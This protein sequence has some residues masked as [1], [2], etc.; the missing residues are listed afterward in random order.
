MV[1][2]TS[3]F[4]CADGQKPAKFLQK[5]NPMSL[6][7]EGVVLARVVKAFSQDPSSEWAAIWEDLKRSGFLPLKVEHTSTTDNLKDVKKNNLT[8]ERY[9][10]TLSAC[11]VLGPR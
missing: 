8:L 9:F 2:S 6:G 10:R 7:V 11:F 4:Y 5:T 1:A 3:N